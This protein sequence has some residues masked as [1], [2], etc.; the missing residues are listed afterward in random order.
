VNLAAVRKVAVAVFPRS[1][2]DRVPYSLVIFAV[3][4]MAASFP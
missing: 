2:R 4:L 1:V 3:I